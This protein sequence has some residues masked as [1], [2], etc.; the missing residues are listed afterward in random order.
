[1]SHVA[2]HIE[3]KMSWHMTHVTCHI[4]NCMIS[5]LTSIADMTSV[6]LNTI[7]FILN[8]L[9]LSFLSTCSLAT[10]NKISAWKTIFSVV[11]RHQHTLTARMKIYAYAY[12]S[13]HAENLLCWGHNVRRNRTVW[14]ALNAKM[15]LKRRSTKPNFST[16]FYFSTGL[17]FL[18]KICCRICVL[19]TGSC[20][21]SRF[22]ISFFN[23]SIQDI[24][25]II[26]IYNPIFLP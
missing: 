6:Y 10:V 9:T 3:C 19:A 7:V 17:H 15:Q 22:I 1:M 14:H 26:R 18:R 13:Q 25:Y 8:I 21:G 12:L 5:H 16:L 20:S 4:T 23:L 24:F 11:T 2:S